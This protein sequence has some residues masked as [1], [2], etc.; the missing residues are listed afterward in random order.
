MNEDCH[1]NYTQVPAI[2]PFYFDIFYDGPCG[3]KCEKQVGEIPEI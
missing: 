2:D 1:L 3:V